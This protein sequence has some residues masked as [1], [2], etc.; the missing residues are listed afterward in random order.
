M[1]AARTGAAGWVA[2]SVTLWALCGGAVLLA[3]VGANVLEVASGALQPLTGYRFTGAVELTELGA[4]VAV[5]AFLPWCQLHDAHVTAD[6]FTARAGPRAVA[7]MRLAASLVALAVFAVLLWRMTGGLADQR[8]YGYRTAIL[9][10]PV[11]WAYVPALVSLA[12]TL[13]AAVVR[14]IE[15]GRDVAAGRP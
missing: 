11:W 5:F 7:V 13:A 8:G 10:L 12:L 14:I 9:S 1:P 4:A 6:I 2:R 3:V 15:T